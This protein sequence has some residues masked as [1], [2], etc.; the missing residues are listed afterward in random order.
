MFFSIIIPVYNRP[1]EVDELLLSLHDQ[2][3]EHFEVIVVEDGS[4]R[5]SKDVVEKHREKLSITYHEKANTGP[6]LSRNAGALLAQHE[7]LIF[8]DSDCII[9]S[10]Y[11]ESVNRFVTSRRVELFGGPDAAM[12]TFTTVQK[13][14]NYSMTSFFT[15]GGIRG[16]KRSMDAFL[17]RG[18]NM[19]IS[20][21]AFEAVGGY[22]GMRFGED[23][24]L[25]LRLIAAGYRSALIPEACVYHKR[26]TTYRLFFKQVYNSGIARVNLHLLHPGSMKPVHVLPAL[27]TVGMGAILVASLFFPVLLLVP[28]VYSLLLFLD[29]LS[30]NRSTKVAMHSIASS[31][32]QL[33]GYGSG[34]LAAAWKRLVLREGEFKAFEKKFYD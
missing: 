21:E 22:R 31:C 33:A 2:T 18:F 34:F 29:S 8:F 27:F 28:A 12:D 23:I 13:A 26:R 15:T 3:H 16:R 19:G 32:I 17:P 5:G 7:Y 20:K 11:L 14:I 1:D 25:S 10:T 6:G 4:S 24:D 30:K 9:P